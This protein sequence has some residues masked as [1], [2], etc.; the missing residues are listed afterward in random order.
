M[1]VL[2]LLKVAEGHDPAELG[3]HRVPENRM[4]WDL[5]LKGTVREMHLRQ[6][7]TGAVLVLEAADADEA[8]RVVGALPMVAA[9]VLA[10]ELVPLG[11]FRP[12]ET[13][14]AT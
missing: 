10:A 1:K 9:G 13:L 3:P 11:P 2:V 5:Y 6:D 7:V 8:R 4:I 12:L 14:F